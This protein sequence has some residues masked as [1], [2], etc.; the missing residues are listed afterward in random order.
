MM[1]LKALKAALSK[2]NK[3][4]FGGIQAQKTSLQIKLKELNEAQGTSLLSLLSLLSFKIDIPA[5]SL[6]NSPFI[7]RDNTFS[8]E[9]LKQFYFRS[10][11]PFSLWLSEGKR[12]LGHPSIWCPTTKLQKSE[13]NKP[14]RHGSHDLQFLTQSKNYPT[15]FLAF[16]SLSDAWIY[17]P[18][19]EK[20]E[21]TVKDQT[22]SSLKLDQ[23]NLSL[24]GISQKLI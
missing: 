6:R 4:T 1:K 5:S 17:P 18:T 24:G 7:F 3:D 23:V 20:K 15:Y 22:T 21:S 8:H 14:K 2:W 12:K 13:E 11:D 9:L 16:L 19:P 10:S